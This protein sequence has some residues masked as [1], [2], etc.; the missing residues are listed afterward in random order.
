VAVTP[1]R[2]L[3]QPSADAIAG[4]KVTVFAAEVDVTGG[5]QGLWQWLVQNQEAF[6]SEVVVARHHLAHATHPT[7]R[8]HPDRKDQT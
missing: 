5:H 3:W 8:R 4:A 1:A 6:W 2:S 7:E